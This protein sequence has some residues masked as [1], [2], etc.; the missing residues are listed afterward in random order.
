MDRSLSLNANFTGDRWL[1]WLREQGVDFVTVNRPDRLPRVVSIRIE[2]KPVRVV[3][4][5]V[6]RALGAEWKDSS[7]GPALVFPPEALVLAAPSAPEPPAPLPSRFPRKL[8]GNNLNEEEGPLPVARY[9]PGATMT[10]AARPRAVTH[11]SSGRWSR[12]TR[13]VSSRKSK[14]RASRNQRSQRA[15]R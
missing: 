10:V 11:R 7:A 12:N 8:P 6:A 2:N 15:R 3:M 14:S 4:S 9:T 13:A 1:G 5:E